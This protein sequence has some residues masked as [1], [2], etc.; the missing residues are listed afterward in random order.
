VIYCPGLLEPESLLTEE[1]EKSVSST[2]MH[3]KQFASMDIDK[4][5]NYVED[6]GGFFYLI[7]SDG[8]DAAFVAEGYVEYV[9]LCPSNERFG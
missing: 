3:I 7:N 6:V 4:Y 9:R 8:V 1:I 5:L 2:P